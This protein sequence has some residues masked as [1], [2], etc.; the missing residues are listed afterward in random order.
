MPLPYT[1]RSIELRCSLTPTSPPGPSVDHRAHITGLQ[2]QSSICS[3]KPYNGTTLSYLPTYAGPVEHYIFDLSGHRPPAWGSFTTPTST[4]TRSLAAKTARRIS[5]AM[6]PSS[7]AYVFLSPQRL[8]FLRT[9]F[10]PV[11][12]YPGSYSPTATKAR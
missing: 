7:H 12:L 1:H 4:R 3:I 8:L 9:F 5:R 2:P 10:L 11:Q 6:M